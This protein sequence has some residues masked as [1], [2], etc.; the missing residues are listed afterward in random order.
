[1]PPRSHEL[2]YM[3]CLQADHTARLLTSRPN[4]LSTVSDI[5]DVKLISSDTW[6]HDWKNIARIQNIRSTKSRFRDDIAV[7]T[8]PLK[9]S[10]ENM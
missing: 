4:C 3:Q 10:Y 8:G 6:R 1:M 7:Y 5:L 2:K 9:A